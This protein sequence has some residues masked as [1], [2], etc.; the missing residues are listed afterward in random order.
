MAKVNT[1]ESNMKYLH[2]QVFFVII[3]MKLSNGFTQTLKVL[4][5]DSVFT[6]VLAFENLENYNNDESDLKM[7]Q[8]V[9]M[10]GDTVLLSN[11]LAQNFNYP[12]YCREN[13]F[14]PNRTFLEVKLN[15]NKQIDSVNLLRSY[16]Q[17]EASEIINLFKNVKSVLVEVKDLLIIVNVH[18]TYKPLIPVG[19]VQLEKISK[20]RIRRKY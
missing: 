2:F 12:L 9:L 4:D 10:T 3:L 16:C 11:Y 13:G 7:I 15:S 19:I 17:Q 5:G 20:R 6:H 8:C 1:I 14:S 18:V